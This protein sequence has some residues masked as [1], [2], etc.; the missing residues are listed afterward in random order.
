MP[1]NSGTVKGGPRY[2]LQLE[3]LAV[4]LLTA[5]LYGGTG[6]SWWL[7]AALILAP[8]VAILGY[9]A[10]PRAGAIAYN[11]L[12]TYLGPILLFAISRGDGTAA[13]VAL[14]W[15]AHIG[16][17]R[18]FGFGLKYA[19]GFRITHLSAPKSE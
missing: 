3:G 14:V 12:H 17:D 7:F 19:S 2:L 9:L 6:S 5:T 15:A 1:N 18:A 4:L 13:A 10:G 8:D 16:M 11:A